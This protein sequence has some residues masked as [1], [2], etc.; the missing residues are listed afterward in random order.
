MP[1]DRC[2]AYVGYCDAWT[3]NASL[4]RSSSYRKCSKRRILGH[5]AQATSLLRIDG[6]TICSRTVRGFD[7]GSVMEFAAA[8]DITARTRASAATIDCKRGTGFQSTG[9]GRLGRLLLCR[10]CST[11]SRR[12]RTICLLCGATSHRAGSGCVGCR[13]PSLP[14]RSRSGAMTGLSAIGFMPRYCD[15]RPDP[16]GMAVHDQPNIRRENR[17]AARQ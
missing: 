10:R 2:R 8:R 4:T 3:L 16:S 17:E 12:Y 6:T 9:A 15:V 7:F 13:G 11:H 5:S 1:F 14:S